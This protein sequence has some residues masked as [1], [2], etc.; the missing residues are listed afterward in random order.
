MGTWKVVTANSGSSS[1]SRSSASRSTSN[2]GGI[3][4]NRIPSH[5][6]MEHDRARLQYT[7]EDSSD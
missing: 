4:R 7:P 6:L 1:L 5:A 3:G 2:I